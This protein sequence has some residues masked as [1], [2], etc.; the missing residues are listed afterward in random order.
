M[1]LGPSLGPFFL[2]FAEI[3]HPECRAHR[4]KDTDFV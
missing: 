3:Y 2:Y 1:E 4:E